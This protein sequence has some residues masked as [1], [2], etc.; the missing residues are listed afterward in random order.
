MT[1]LSTPINNINKT[2][3]DN[4]TVAVIGEEYDARLFDYPMSKLEKK[5]TYKGKIIRPEVTMTK[6]VK[7]NVVY[8]TFTPTRESNQLFNDI[9]GTPRLIELFTRF[10]AKVFQDQEIKK[11]VTDITEA[12]G[13]RFALWV[14]EKVSI[15]FDFC[16]L[17][18]LITN[19]KI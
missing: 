4:D 3:D 11:M 1:T 6:F 5:Y 13:E 9:G 8:G 17:N 7:L 12:H 10:Y 19:Q 15:C 18:L 16:I 14:S 2:D